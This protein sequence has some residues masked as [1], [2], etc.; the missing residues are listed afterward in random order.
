MFSIIELTTAIVKD[1]AS[2]VQTLL[3]TSGDK[4]NL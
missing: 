3:I 1:V 2:S 4:V